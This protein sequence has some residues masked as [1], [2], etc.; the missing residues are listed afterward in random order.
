MTGPSTMHAGTSARIA[1]ATGGA[2]DAA[3]F[4]VEIQRP[5]EHGFGEYRTSTA[6]H[7]GAFSPARPGVYRFRSRMHLPGGDGTGFSPVHTI[8][9]S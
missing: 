2:P 6:L 1:W 7:G 5:G 4:D 3:L 9:V 8:S